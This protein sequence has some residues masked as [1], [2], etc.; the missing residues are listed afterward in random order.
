VNLIGMPLQFHGTPAE[1]RQA[2]P[3]FGQHTE[4]V[5]MD[6][7]GYGWDDIERLKNAEVI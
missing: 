3:N 7:L 6:V 4:E 5:L 2:A 1:R